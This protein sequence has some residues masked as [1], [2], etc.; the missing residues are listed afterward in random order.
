MFRLRLLGAPMMVWQD[1]PFTLPRLQARALFFRLAA[2]EQP[3]SREAL[4]DLLWSDTAPATARR[5]LTRLLSYL[6]SQLPRPDM[7]LVGK[8]AVSL[9]PHLAATDA[10]QFTHLCAAA[11]PVA[12]ETAV[13]LYQGP[14]L[15]GFNLNGSRAFDDWLGQEQRRLEQTCLET[16]R[17]LVEANAHEPGTAIRFARMYLETDDLAEAIHRRLI[18]LY[19][20][21]GDRGA[22]LRQYE[23]CVLVLE[24]ELGVPPLPETRAAYEAARDGHH[25]TPPK[26]P[27]PEWATLPGL[28][29]PLIGRE[30]TWKKLEKAYGRFQGGGVIFISGEPGVGKSRLMQEFATAQDG[31]TLTGN[32][33]AGS[34]TAPYAP[35]AQALRQALSLP[36]RCGIASPSGWLKRPVY[37]RN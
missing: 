5:N 18:T 19:A 9:D 24:R 14:F 32:N 31:F 3:V 8:T 36:A 34:Q 2:A 12:W 17:R 23:Q 6:R 33:A 10:V 21:D 20:G 1:R 35:L 28:D 11:D 4:A 25:L 26:P 15:A 22:A 16:L 13:S 29:L 27:E 7:L 37:C 30:E